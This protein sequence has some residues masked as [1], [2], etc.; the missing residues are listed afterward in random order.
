MNDFGT[1]NINYEF[2]L[3]TT[4]LFSLV[5]LTVEEVFSCRLGAELILPFDD[6]V[7]K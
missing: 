7:L 6:M 5:L 1:A 3:Y 4:L 2:S